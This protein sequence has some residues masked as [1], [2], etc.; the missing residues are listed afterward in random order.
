LQAVRIED[1]SLDEVAGASQERSRFDVA[2]VFSTKYEPAHPFFWRWRAWEK[3]KARFFGFHRD[4][5][6]AVAAQM[7]GGRI[8]FTEKSTGQWV[9]VIEIERMYEAQAAVPDSNN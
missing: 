8:V 1:F 2:L 4:V 5:P 9:A 7:L 6:P 3:V